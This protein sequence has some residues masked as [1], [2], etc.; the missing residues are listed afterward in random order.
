M[1]GP[2]SGPPV[3]LVVMGVSGTGKTTLA[4]GLA[5]Q[6]GWVFQEGDDLHPATNVAKMAAGRPLIGI[7]NGFQVLTRT[8]LLPGALGHNSAGTFDCRWVELEPDPDSVSVWTRGLDASLHCPIAHGEGR[9][10]HPD[11]GALAAAGQI[12][13]EEIKRDL[14]SRHINMIAIAGMIVRCPSHSS[15]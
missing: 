7:C 3:V 6:L 2:T 1:T 9:Y 5:A 14:H 4:A 13:Q 15:P 10:V 12:A 11:P 8:R